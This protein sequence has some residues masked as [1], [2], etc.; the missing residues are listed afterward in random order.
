MATC[1][2]RSRRHQLSWTAQRVSRF[3]H[4]FA[5][6]SLFLLLLLLQRYHVV[7][8]WELAERKRKARGSAKVCVFHFGIQTTSSAA[9]RRFSFL[10]DLIACNRMKAGP[11][12]LFERFR[13]FA[14]SESFAPGAL[15]PAPSLCVTWGKLFPPPKGIAGTSFEHRCVKYC[16]LFAC[17]CFHS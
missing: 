15:L 12:S 14:A 13:S 5:S 6:S 17:D 1:K 11:G 4:A 16:Y 7:R 8:R 3:R 2:R 10:L 9:C